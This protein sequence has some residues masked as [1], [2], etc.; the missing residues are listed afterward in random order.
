VVH[1]TSSRPSNR[2]GKRSFVPRVLREWAYAGFT[3]DVLGATVSL[4]AT[5][6]VPLG[7]LAPLIVLGLIV[8]SYRGWHERELRHEGAAHNRPQAPSQSAGQPASTALI[9]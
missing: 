1:H 3:F 7:A 4:L 9:G 8:P 5:G 2:L 6:E